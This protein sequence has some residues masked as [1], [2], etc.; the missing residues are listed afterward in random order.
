MKKLIIILIVVLLLPIPKESKIKNKIVYNKKL[1]NKTLPKEDYLFK[2]IIPKINIDKKIYNINSPKNNV[3]INIE[4]LKE[5]NIN[6]KFI[7]LASHSGNNNN[8]YFNKLV[9]LSINDLIYIY[10]NSTIYTYKINKIYYI[11]KTGYMTIDNNKSDKLILITCSKTNKT[12][13]LIIESI[14]I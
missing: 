8:A 2:L 5:S 11:N 4:L 10:Y 3:E 13:Q 14:L 6:N 1:V 7:I 12:K 9:Y